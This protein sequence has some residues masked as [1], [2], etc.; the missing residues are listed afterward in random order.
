MRP[1]I[2]ISRLTASLVV[3]RAWWSRHQRKALVSL[4][5]IQL[6]GVILTVWALYLAY[7]SQLTSTLQVKALGQISGELSTRFCGKFP[8]NVFQI[9]SLLQD[10]MDYV[11]SNPSAPP[12]QVFIAVDHLLYGFISNHGA[13]VK[14]LYLIEDL[15]KAGV[16]VTI[17]HYGPEVAKVDT[18][19]QFEGVDLEAFFGPKGLFEV[20]AETY[21]KSRKPWRDWENGNVELEKIGT[22]A[23]TDEKKGAFS[24]FID[25]LLTDQEERACQ[26]LFMKG[27]NILQVV[28]GPNMKADRIHDQVI[29]PFYI[30]YSNA[31]DRRMIVSYESRAKSAIESSIFSRESEFVATMYDQALGYRKSRDAAGQ[32]RTYSLSTVNQIQDD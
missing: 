7:Q 28:S 2:I 3:L 1:K 18:A 8:E 15:L 32:L 17:L 25:W 23:A 6:I 11:T 5:V 10:H 16:N 24:E 30:W 9:S 26:V 13:A 29:L 14:N 20:F 4:Q 22:L 19:Q 21:S 27:A 12:G 31:G